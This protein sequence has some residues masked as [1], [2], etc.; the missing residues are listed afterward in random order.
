MLDKCVCV[1]ACVCAPEC[2]SAHDHGW[3]PC[4]QAACLLPTSSFTLTLLVMK[5]IVLRSFFATAIVATNLRSKA[6]GE[7]S[8]ENSGIS[9]V[10][11]F[12]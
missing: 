10:Y 12:G 11:D 5:V 6:K 2:A 1:C 8:E 7:G 9:E 3:E 4:E